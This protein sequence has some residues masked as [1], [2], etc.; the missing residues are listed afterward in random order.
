M[1]TLVSI[2]PWLRL[3][4]HVLTDMILRCKAWKCS[5][6]DNSYPY[7][8]HTDERLGDEAAR[9]F[10]FESCSGAV[11]SDVL[12]KQIPALNANQ[13][14]ILIS[15]GNTIAQVYPMNIGT[16]LKRIMT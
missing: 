13:Q 3:K 12:K 7:L 6:Y 5:R 2:S 9:N 15:A 11:T 14:V 8:I 16:V 4:K 10:Q 1:I